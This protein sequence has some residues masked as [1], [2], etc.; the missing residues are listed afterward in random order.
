M[1][2][3]CHRL[4]S[5]RELR[6]HLERGRFV[7]CRDLPEDVVGLLAQLRELQVG[8]LELVGAG[9]HHHA[10]RQSHRHQQ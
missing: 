3:R 8:R 7:D 6:L 1:R 5:V 10:K 4:G 9:E 2:Q